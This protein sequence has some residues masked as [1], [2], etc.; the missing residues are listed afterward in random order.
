MDDTTIIN[1]IMIVIEDSV[2]TMIVYN[3]EKYND[4]N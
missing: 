4:C 2:N 1:M 3:A